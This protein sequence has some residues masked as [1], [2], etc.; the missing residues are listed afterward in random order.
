MQNKEY[1]EEF[2]IIKTRFLN[3]YD[4]KTMQK[5]LN[6]MVYEFEEQNPDYELFNMFFIKSGTVQV[7]II[8][9]WRKKI[10]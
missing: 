5:E 6:K 8:I 7:Y 10:N 9:L 4:E 3:P 1:P 2:R